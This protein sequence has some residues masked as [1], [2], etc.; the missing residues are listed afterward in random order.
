MEGN[1][2]RN[3]QNLSCNKWKLSVLTHKYLYVCFV[4]VGSQAE[5]L[6]S[7]L[8]NIIIE[9]ESLNEMLGENSKN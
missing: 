4:R 2:V 3:I 7:L 8:D 6:K 9:I 5:V 1:Y